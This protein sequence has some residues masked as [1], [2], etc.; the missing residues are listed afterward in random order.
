MRKIILLLIFTQCFAFAKDYYNYNVAKAA[1]YDGDYKKAVQ[2][3]QKSCQ[4][5]KIAAA[6]SNL[7]ILYHQGLGVKQDYSKAKKYFEKACNDKSDEIAVACY[8]L[9][10]LY[11]DGQGVKQDHLKAK[12]HFGKACDLKHKTGCD[13]YKDLSGQGY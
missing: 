7:G 9:G 12:E 13:M 4:D 5:D 2:Y 6:C 3:Y 11:N 1:D 8:G 10:L